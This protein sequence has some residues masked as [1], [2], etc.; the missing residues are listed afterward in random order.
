M[1]AQ[2][3]YQSRA[4]QEAESYQSRA[5]QEAVGKRGYTPSVHHVAVGGAGGVYL[6]AASDMMADSVVS[7]RAGQSCGARVRAAPV[8]IPSGRAH[9]VQYEKGRPWGRRSDMSADQQQLDELRRRIDA[10][11]DQLVAL[12]NERAKAAARIGRIKH[13]SGDA[14]YAPARERGVLDRVVRANSGPLSDRTIR[15]IYRELMSGSFT[16]ERPPRVAYLGPPGSFSHLAA[17]R[18]FGASVEYEPLKHIGAVF[19]AIEREHADLGLAPVENTIGGGVID[20]LDALATRS[21]KICAEINLS[22]QHHVLANCPLERVER[23]YSKP[24]VFAQCQNWLTETGMIGKTIA[25][26]STSRAAEQAAA[27]PGTAAVG[28][29]LAGEIYGLRKICDRIEDDPGNLTRFLVIS[30]ESA[31]PTGNDK[32]SLFMVMSHKPGSLV[33]A[34]QV[35]RV[36]GVNMTYIESRPKRGHQF[37]YCFFVDIEGHGDDSLTAAAISDVGAHCSALRVLGS[38]PR[39]DEV[40]V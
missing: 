24:E 20:T 13:T 7:V 8:V 17:R 15:A 14:T 34:L 32:T 16:L 22:V 5:R 37:E 36:A 11:D 39:A 23:I 26:A 30:R 33:E 12:I 38:F 4:R 28:S 19:E 18:K 6:S 9:S 27:E 21:V 29:E 35:L 1:E 2:W 10:I 3:S 40:V 31:Q 25:V